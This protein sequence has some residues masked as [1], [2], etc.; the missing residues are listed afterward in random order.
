VGHRL[1]AVGEAHGRDPEDERGGHRRGEQP[2]R[3]PAGGATLR[4][5]EGRPVG[6]ELRGE[7]LGT[8]APQ[9]PRLGDL[10]RAA[11]CPGT[12]LALAFDRRRDDGGRRV[13]A[14][15]PP[16]P[17]HGRGH[18]PDRQEPDHDGRDARHADPACVGEGGGA[19]EEE[20]RGHP[21]AEPRPA[22]DDQ[23]PELRALPLDQLDDRHGVGRLVT[24]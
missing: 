3:P 21:G 9:R 17:D 5:S 2:A 19:G 10:Q 12:Q 4:G 8:A 16:R 11:Q 18:G 1:P 24:A 20:Q 6:G 23:A 7:S 13:A 15:P 14:D 22:E